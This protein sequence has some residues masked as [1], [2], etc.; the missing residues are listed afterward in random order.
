MD[1]LVAILLLFSQLELHELP[2]GLKIQE[3]DTRGNVK[4]FVFIK[5]RRAKGCLLER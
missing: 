4:P 3:G 2:M 5:F 1:S